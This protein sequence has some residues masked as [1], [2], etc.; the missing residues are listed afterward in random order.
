MVTASSYDW[1]EGY[2]EQF[3]GGFL[4]RKKM[5]SLK[6]IFRFRKPKQADQPELLNDTTRQKK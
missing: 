4:W 6:E 5:D 3:G 1:L 2:V